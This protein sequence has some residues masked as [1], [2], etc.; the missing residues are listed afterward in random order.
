MS[1][2]WIEPS[3]VQGVGAVAG[4]VGMAVA[5]GAGIPGFDKSLSCAGGAEAG[6]EGAGSGRSRCTARATN[7]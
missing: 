4:R 3:A 7:V 6:G 2:C 1:A 5:G